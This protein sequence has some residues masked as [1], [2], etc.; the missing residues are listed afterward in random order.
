VKSKHGDFWDHVGA[1]M[2]EATDEC[3][4]AVKAGKLGEFEKAWVDPI[5]RLRR[6]SWFVDARP[7]PRKVAAQTVRADIT[8]MVAYYRDA[9]RLLS[10][11]W[12]RLLRV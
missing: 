8:V 5:I 10:S 2:K 12:V 3:S 1:F 9:E 7:I 11:D 6:Y 4:K